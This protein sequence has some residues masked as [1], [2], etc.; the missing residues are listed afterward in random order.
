MG[1]ES[2]LF[3]FGASVSRIVFVVTLAA[4]WMLC[5]LLPRSGFEIGVHAKTCMYPVVTPNLENSHAY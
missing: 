3:L 5:T 4:L 2:P 1:T